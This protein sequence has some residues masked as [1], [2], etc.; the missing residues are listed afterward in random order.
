MIY[1]VNKKYCLFLAL[2]YDRFVATKP[3][4]VRIPEEWLPRLDAAAA[5]LGTNRARLIAFCAQ[6]FAEAFGKEGETMMP[7]N[8]K[9]ILRALDGRTKPP[10]GFYRQ[11][12]PKW[13]Q[14][15]SKT[16]DAGAKLLK[17]NAAS[18]S[19]SDSK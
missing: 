12:P 6:T 7:P 17:K 3:I 10:I 14:L 1:D 9:D 18:A 16:A 8:W 19:G 4:P 13:N 11:R 5:A 2:I 15:N